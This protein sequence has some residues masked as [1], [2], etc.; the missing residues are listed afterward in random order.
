M[1]MERLSGAFGLFGSVRKQVWVFLAAM[2][3]TGVVMALGVVYLA[4]AHD[5]LTFGGAPVGT[6]PETLVQAL[7]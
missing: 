1:A 4:P 6:E 5:A 2:A 3:L 7:K